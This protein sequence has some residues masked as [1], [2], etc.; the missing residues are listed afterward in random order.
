MARSRIGPLALETPLGGSKSSIFRAIHVQ[1]KA[2]VAVRLFPV[3]IGL[4]P[5]V[6]R[7]FAEQMESLKLLRHRGIARCFGGG[8]DA[9]DAYLVYE[10]V[11]GESLE[12]LLERR[13]RLPW[14]TVLD[15]GLQ[16]CEALQYAHENGWVHGRLRPDKL[17]TTLNNSI[18]KIADFRKDLGASNLL[19]KPASPE[20]LAF[21]APETFESGYAL[22]PAADLYSLGAIMYQSLTSRP[23]F[24]GGNQQHIKNLIIETQPP[25]VST[26]VFDCPVWLSAIVEQLLDKNPNRRPFSATAV[27]M[28]LQ[29]AQQHASQGISVAEHAVSGFSPLQLNTDRDEAAKALGMK[30]KKE[31]KHAANEVP[32]ME[33]TW[34]LALGILLAVGSIYYYTRPLSEDQLRARAEPLLEQEESVAYDEAKERYLLPLVH[35]YPDGKH[36]AWANEQ[37]EKIDML[38]AERLLERNRRFNRPPSSEAERKYE[39]A[40]RYE[41]FGDRITALERYKAIVELMKDVPEEKPFVNLSKRQI[42]RL[43]DLSLSNEDLKK[44]LTAKLDE[45]DDQWKSGDVVAPKKLWE[46]IIKLYNGNKEMI[47]F[48]RRSQQRLDAMKDADST[49]LED[50]TENASEVNNAK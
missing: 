34:V 27:S 18:I 20:Q 30:P 41:R 13:E 39:E 19:D 12:L 1:Q 32:L 37:L 17:L 47:E 38:D 6:K 45:A 22:Q 16:I 26:I 23:P 3:P 9:R 35:Q 8:F 46:S 40:M 42:K 50:S 10:L 11:E 44:F 7:E 5:E 2:Q 49:V 36:I 15:Y 14:E 31:R 25:P 33:R 4:T 29:T 43:E 24:E 48:V 21:V 28:A